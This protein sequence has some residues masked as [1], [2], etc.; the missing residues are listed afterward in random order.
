[1]TTFDALHQL[2][3]VIMVLV[4]S[5]AIEGHTANEGKQ[6]IL[7]AAAAV[8]LR[9]R[10]KLKAFGKVAPVEERLWRDVVDGRSW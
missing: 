10:W 6:S 2:D 4:T 8:A 3:E 9:A 5:K 7:V 1:M